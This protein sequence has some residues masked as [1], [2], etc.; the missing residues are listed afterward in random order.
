MS[1][2]DIR[3]VTDFEDIYD[4]FFGQDGVDFRRV[5]TSKMARSDMFEFL[6]DLGMKIPAHGRVV[7]LV[8]ILSVKYGQDRAPY[9]RVVVYLDEA[10]CRGHGKE[11]M[12]L[13]EAVERTPHHYASEYVAGPQRGASQRMIQI[14]SRSFWL[15]YRNRADWR[16]NHGDDVSVAVVGESERGYS[17]SINLPL[18][19]IDFVI[20]EDNSLH[21]IDFSAAPEMKGT[22]LDQKISPEDV[23]DEIVASMARRAAS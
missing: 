18:F 21:A 4:H 8:D 22:G 3:L 20:G 12:L 9:S 11:L 6:E 23:F 13:G 2:R 15:M 19:A 14:G 10:A 7:D 16:S 17:E 1:R 5:R